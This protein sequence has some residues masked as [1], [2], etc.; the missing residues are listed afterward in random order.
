MMSILA[1]DLKKLGWVFRSHCLL[2]NSPRRWCAAWDVLAR[3]L[4]TPPA[5]KGKQSSR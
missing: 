3:G 1:N 2:G 5:R 4:A